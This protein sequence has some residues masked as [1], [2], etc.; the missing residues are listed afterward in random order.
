M[1]YWP[2][3]VQTADVFKAGQD[4]IDL[5]QYSKQSQTSFQLL[6]L[7]YYR[8]TKSKSL[9][10]GNQLMPVQNTPHQHSINYGNYEVWL[11]EKKKKGKPSTQNAHIL[12]FNIT[13][14]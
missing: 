8:V 4:L 3:D 9:L 2:V 5:E 7:V 6:V 10:I 1:T 13:A 12:Y 14:V 11:Q